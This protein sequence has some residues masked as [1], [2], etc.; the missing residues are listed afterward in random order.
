[1]SPTWE[2]C[3]P[4]DERTKTHAHTTRDLTIVRDLALRSW[5]RCCWFPV[6]MR[7]FLHV[8]DDGC[9]GFGV[10]VVDLL[11]VAIFDYAPPEFQ[12]GR[13][14]AV[15]DGELVWHHNH[16]L[17]LL[18]ARQLLVDAFYNLGV[19]VLH[20]WLQHEFRARGEGNFV[21]PRPLLQQC[22]VRR[23]DDSCEFAAIA[24][25]SRHSYQRIHFE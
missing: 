6:S 3:I 16:S 8:W 19:Q 23:D 18:E 14:S 7:L 2:Y 4:N 20:L 5:W 11:A 25:K 9:F 15:L 22:E 12:A 1:M 10:E 17:Q 13:H 21:V 24:Y